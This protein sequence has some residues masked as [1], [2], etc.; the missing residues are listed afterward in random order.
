MI[1]PEYISFISNLFK[2][3]K[4]Y[5]QAF[6]ILN[7]LLL[8][9]VIKF[10]ILNSTAIDKEAC[11]SRIYHRFGIVFIFDLYQGWANYSPWATCSLQQPSV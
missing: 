3:Q 8:K 1:A 7:I 6:I 11:I 10:I 2:T 4:L 9:F 5:Y